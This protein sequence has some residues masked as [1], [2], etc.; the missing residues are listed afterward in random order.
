[1]DF[2]KWLLFCFDYEWFPAYFF[3]LIIV[4]ETSILWSWFQFCRRYSCWWFITAVCLLSNT[5]NNIALAWGKLFSFLFF[6]SLEILQHSPAWFWDRLQETSASCCWK[7]L[8]PVS[9]SMIWY[10]PSFSFLLANN[11]LV[12]GKWKMYSRISRVWLFLSLPSG[13]FC[14]ANRLPLCLDIN[15]IKL[16]FQYP[17]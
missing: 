3:A 14:S 9:L 17:H 4:K 13:P 8:L 15:F 1:M 2:W 16:H 6:V 10:L 12:N 7:T 5:D 11:S